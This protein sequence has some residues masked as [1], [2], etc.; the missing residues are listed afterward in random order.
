LLVIPAVDV[1][2]GKC[3]RLR[4]GSPS[5]RKIY[6]EAPVQIIKKFSDEGAELIHL[7]DLD[8]ALGVGRNH[9]IIRR[10]IESGISKI[11][12]AGGI[13]DMEKAE[14]ILKL[15]AYRIVFGTIAAR[16]PKLVSDIARRYGADRV[17]VAVDTRGGKVSIE[18]WTQQLDVDYL[19]FAG[20][21]E[22]TGAGVLIFTQIDVDGTLKGCAAAGVA[23]LLGRVRIPV[24]ASGGIGELS[25]LVALSKLG[26]HGAIVGTA[27]YERR[28]TLKDAMRAVVYVD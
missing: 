25:D 1:M 3:V 23:K 14:S 9:E 27:L 19:E 11:Q 13:R 20:S 22:S 26:V 24:I 5:Q 8:A 10:C 2:Q 28:F 12:V 21:I 16:H 15:G 17:A 18:G 4:Q 7:V 6:D